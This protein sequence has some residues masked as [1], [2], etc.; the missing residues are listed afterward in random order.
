MNDLE[1]LTEKDLEHLLEQLNYWLD[2]TALKKENEKLRQKI[3]YIE[4]II[5]N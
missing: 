2:L 4:K 5:N 3:K 1:E